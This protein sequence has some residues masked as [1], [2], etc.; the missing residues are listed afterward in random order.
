MN[1]WP[2]PRT[3]HPN[4]IPGPLLPIAL[5][6]GSQQLVMNRKRILVVDDS[7]III[8][9]LSMKLKSSGYDVLTAMDGGTAVSTVRKE[10]PDLILLDITYPPDVAHGGGVAW[11]GFL[12]MDWLKRMDDQKHIPIV[13]ITGGDP[14][15]LKD[16]SLAAG[17]VAFLQKPIDNDQL[18]ATIRE[19]IGS[20]DGQ[21]EPEP[22]A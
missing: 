16:R 2:Q 11:D 17:A 19:I 15:K 3:T 5:A 13:I 14:A 4:P 12:I 21:A 9:T 18:L 1:T 8:K 10:R 22:A 6:S 20:A 7:A